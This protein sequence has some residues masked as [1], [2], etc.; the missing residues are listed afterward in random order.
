MLW[1]NAS[2][3]TCAMR[4]PLVVP[5]PCEREQG[6]DRRR[7][8]TRLAVGGEVVEPDER[9]GRGIH[10]VGVEPARGRWWCG[11]APAG[12]RS[13]RRD[14][15]LVAPP[16]RRRTA[17]RTRR[18]AADA[19]H[20]DVRVGTERTVDA[21]RESGEPPSSS[22]SRARPRARRDACCASS[23][24]RWATCPVACTPASVRPATTRRTSPAED[25]G[26]CVLQRL[27][28]GAQARLPRP[29]AE[30]GAVVGDVQAEAHPFSLRRGAGRV[31]GWKSAGDASAR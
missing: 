13:R 20:G 9:A 21:A 29:A 18:G 7:F 6:A 23:R 15:V 17:R 31:R 3:F 12:R 27:L 1:Q 30:M 25:A 8:L 22:P 5:P 28:H 24:S 14:A 10:R 19:P 26:E 4:T 16:H 11:D 2:A